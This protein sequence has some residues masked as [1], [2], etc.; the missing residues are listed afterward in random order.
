MADVFGARTDFYRARVSHRIHRA[1]HHGSAFPARLHEAMVYAADGGKRL[2]PLLVYASAETLGVEPARVDAAAAAVEL[3][4]AYSLVHDDLPAMDDDD[5]RRGRPTCHRAYDEATAIL[6]GDALQAAAFRILAEPDAAAPPAEQRLAMVRELA[7]A[8]GSQGMVGGQAVDLAA[9]GR[10]LDV[11]EVEAMHIRKTGTLLLACVRLAAMAGE[12]VDA[13]A[14]EALEAYGKRIG[15]AFQIQDDVLDES[16]DT[17][18][19]GK[20]AGQDQRNGKP[21]YVSAAGLPAARARAEELFREATDA[22]DRF[23]EAAE[24]LRWIADS[25]RARRH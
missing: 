25:L 17:A 10:T 15:L 24:P 4:H 3:I 2:R 11:A 19:L 6:V 21:T 7:E 12:S 18:V 13:A 8:A 23:G 14:T 22:L 9:V 5:L 16:G 20:H 1:L